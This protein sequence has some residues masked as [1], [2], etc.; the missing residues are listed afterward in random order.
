LT[1]F[2]CWPAPGPPWRT[3]VLPIEQRPDT[4]DGRLVAADHDRQR[5]VPCANVPAGHGRVDRRD[6]LLS[7]ALGDLDGERRLA[8]RQVDEH[9]A[10]LRAA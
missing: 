3:I 5:R 10:G 4:F 9:R 8:R 6:V 7:C 1:I 2:V